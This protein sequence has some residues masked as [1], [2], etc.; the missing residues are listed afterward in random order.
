MPLIDDW[1]SKRA[2]VA[3]KT[4]KQI[5]SYSGN[6]Y[7]RDGND[8]SVQLRDFLNVVGSNQL[9]T[10][11]NQCLSDDSFQEAGLV[12]QDLVN[13]SGRR[14]GFNVV[15][16][17]YHG[18][19]NGENNYDG[20]WIGDDGSA[21]LVEVKSST[22]YTIKLEKLVEYLNRLVQE[23]EIERSKT[24]ILVVVGKGSTR[25]LEQQIRGSRF[26][27]D[28]RVISADALLSLVKVREN[29]DT[30]QTVEKITAILRPNEYTRVDGIVDLVFS[31]TLDTQSD[32]EV[33]ETQHLPI[34]SGE[35]TESSLEPSRTRSNTHR[36]PV[37][38][39][40]ECARKIESAKKWNLVRST[41]S[42]W[43]TLDKRI[44]VVILNS[45]E[46]E[47]RTPSYYWFGLRGH[48]WNQLESTNESYLAL[49]CGSEEQILL[50]PSKFIAERLSSL[51]KTE[52]ENA[53]WWHIVIKKENKG[54][55]L[56][57][58]DLTKYLMP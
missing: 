26:A 4:I 53:M 28:I 44:A 38:F 30:P 11:V 33:E 39:N 19:R 32:A 58:E 43:H 5:V 6:G 16:G 57:Q 24:S 34:T 18:V 48:Q 25:A 21:L 20:L 23:E 8:T 10:Y 55:H 9:I 13:E 37:Q 42:T 49:G 35:T 56:D 47:D 46:H 1:N 31:V 15:P 27:W 40:E 14:L 29:L 51:P 2:E 41:R 45:R 52:R 36:R 22:T 17:L 54:L 12:F 7:L 50:F 3:A